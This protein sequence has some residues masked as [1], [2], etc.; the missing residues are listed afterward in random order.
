MGR[1]VA[2]GRP[3][4]QLGFGRA[5]GP[6]RVDPE[7]FSRNGTRRDQERPEL[8]GTGVVVFEGRT[9]L[10]FSGIAVSSNS[11]NFQVQPRDAKK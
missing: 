5:E 3:A 8:P 7:I 11:Q 4:R 9:V 10:G 2:T 6:G 1:G